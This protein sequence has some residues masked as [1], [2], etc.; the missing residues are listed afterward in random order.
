MRTLP[1]SRRYTYNT[2]ILIVILFIILASPFK[3]FAAQGINH[4]INFQGKLV[5]SDGTNAADGNYDVVFQIY[6]VPSA[7]SPIWTETRTGGNQVAVTGGIFRV[8]LGSVTTLP[9]SVDFNTDNLYLGITV[10]ADSKMTPRVQFASVPQ[11]FNAEKVNGLTV[12]NT[13]DAPFTSTTILKIADG[14]T[15]VVNAGLT[16]SGTDTTTFTF[17]STGGNIVTEDFTQSLTNKTIGS[18]GLTFS[19]ATTDITTVTNEDFSIVPNGSGKVNINTTSGLASFD[20]RA[21]AATGGT[22]AVASASGKTSFSALIVDN[23]GVGDLFTASNSGT[24]RFTVQNDGTLISGKYTGLNAVLYGTQTTGVIGQVNTTSSGLC[25]MSNAATPTWQ[26]CPAGGSGSNWTLSNA[27]GTLSPNNNTLDILVGGTATTSAKFAVLNIAGTLTPVASVSAQNAAGQALALGGDGT[28]QSLRNNI[29]TIGGDTTGDIYVRPLSST[30]MVRIIHGNTGTGGLMLGDFETDATNKTARIKSYAYNSATSLPITMILAN[31][32]TSSN[33]V[34]IGGGSAT[35][36]AATAIYLRTGTTT[37]T[38]TGTTRLF[39]KS[40]GF[41]GIGDDNTTPV[42]RLDVKDEAV[43][44]N[45]VKIALRR[46]GAGDVGISFQQNGTS[47][48]GIVNRSGAGNGLAFVD[49][50]YEGNNGIEVA[51]FY[52]SSGVGIGTLG[53]LPLATLDVKGSFENS[54]TQAVASAS[55]KTSFASLIVDNRGVGDLFTA[56]NSGTSRFTVQNDGTLI[57]GKYTGLN[58]VLYGTQTTG[59]IGQINTTSSGLCLMSNAATPTWQTCPAGGSG[60]NWT[61][62]TTNGTL[63]PINTTL[64]FLWGGTS[65]S[66]ANFKLTGSSALAGT[67]PVASV[68]ARTSYAAFLVDNSGVGDLF[69]AS[70]AGLTQFV[71]KNNGAV[72]IGGG[73]TIP[74]AL[75]DVNGAASLG[76]VLKFRSGT[77][78][79]QATN[80][81]ALTIGGDTTGNVVFPNAAGIFLGV[82][83]ATN[84]LITFFSSGVGETDPSIYADANGNL[85]LTAPTG[86]VQ[87]GNGSG[88]ISM[89]LSNVADVF[90][91][92]KTVTLVA[93][94][95]SVDYTFSRVFTGGANAQGGAILN[96]T[97]TSG[98]SGTINPDLLLVNSALTSGVFSG[99]LARFQQQGVDKFRIQG[100]GTLPVATISANTS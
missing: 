85:I 98:G 60:S 17:P 1:A 37:T 38:T 58:A 16:F 49:N 28:I 45:G 27:N 46:T 94:Y 73:T 25:L 50:Y 31:N 84:G 42:A 82:N 26:T 51:R 5:N 75:L 48:F 77:A 35:E 36:Y 55:G 7:G 97:D 18:T 20:V 14:K 52:A 93:P 79:I 22:L 13:A 67:K 56:S 41:I 91:A 32:L 30:G 64:D 70:S 47:A 19:G 40:D 10:G 12:T 74:T 71:I 88:N 100:L 44:I 34:Q 78:Q 2:I 33:Q 63:Y 39:V 53:N 15:V 24:S 86:T 72:G 76:G 4:Q 29:L 11:A 61:L 59:V 92:D 9:G 57:S 8:S 65:S 21:N 83:E 95:T 23:Q 99:N 6:S 87:M 90:T 54:G 62:D 80:N 69:T 66:A 68:S 81:Q 89:S 96:I 43:D 3:A